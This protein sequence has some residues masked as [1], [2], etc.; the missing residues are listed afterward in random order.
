MP[1]MIVTTVNIVE[2]PL[3]TIALARTWHDIHM[4]DITLRSVQ[5]DA[6]CLA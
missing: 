5:H 4:I 1:S 3:E 6:M 2:I